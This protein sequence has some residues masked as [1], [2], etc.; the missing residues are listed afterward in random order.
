MEPDL[1]IPMVGAGSMC[2]S[3][4]AAAASADANEGL[5]GAFLGLGVEGGLTGTGKAGRGGA[6]RRR[7]LGH[8]RGCVGGCWCGTRSSWPRRCCPSRA[9]PPRRLRAASLSGCR[10]P[11]PRRR[12]CSAP[13]TTT[14]PWRWRCRTCSPTCGWAA[15][16]VSRGARAGGARAKRGGGGGPAG[17]AGGGA[18]GAPRRGGRREGRG[19]GGGRGGRRCCC[20]RR[21]AACAGRALFPLS[22][23]C[24]SCVPLPPSRVP[25]SNT[26]PHRGR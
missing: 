15:L 1:L 3:I 8:W 26:L 21:S 7:R 4:A 6:S 10:R 12:A 9:A 5:L 20:C 23:G 24:M 14:W 2:A 13:S 18:G 16:L 19:G 22:G 11:A 17:A 25:P